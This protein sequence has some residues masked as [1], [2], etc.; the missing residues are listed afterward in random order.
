MSQFLANVIMT[1]YSAT[2]WGFAAF[3]YGLWG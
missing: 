1:G 3:G 2:T